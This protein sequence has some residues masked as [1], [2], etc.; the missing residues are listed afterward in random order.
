M[1][2]DLI[3]KHFARMGARIKLVRHEPVINRWGWNRNAFSGRFSVDVQQDRRGEHFVFN[4][5]TEVEDLLEVDLLQVQPKERHLLLMVKDP[6]VEG[7]PVKDRFLCGHDEREWFV[8]AVPGA[9]S[10]VTGAME[11]LKPVAVRAAQARK[12]LNQKQRIRRRNS[13]FRRQGE[14]FFVP[15]PSAFVQ[16]DAV[17]RN[18]PIARSGGKPHFIQFLYREGGQTIFV[19]P[20]RP[21][22][23]SEVEYERLILS[24]PK[25]KGWAWQTRL[26]NP[27]VLAR[28]EVRHPDHKTITL[29]GWHEVL[30]N[31]ENQSRTMQRVAFID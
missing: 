18:E 13:A 4:V 20:Q 28:G 15:A 26:I 23:V 17:L 11:S 9:V 7:K 22:G 8:A 30:M 24:K 12:G 21:D 3:E 16:K 14:W 27:R 10:T 2:A 5:S 25:A 1:N 19:C 29:H 31:L 6:D